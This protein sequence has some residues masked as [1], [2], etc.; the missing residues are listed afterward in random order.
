MGM[1]LA[2]GAENQASDCRYIASSSGLEARS[3]PEGG[4]FPAGVRR[5]QCSL[6]SPPTRLVTCARSLTGRVS[7]G[8]GWGVPYS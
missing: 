7:E 3:L 5:I 8:M 6:S 4:V 2:A 1:E